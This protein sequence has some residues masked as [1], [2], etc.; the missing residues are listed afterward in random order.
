MAVEE[1]CWKGP[2]GPGG[3]QAE[4]ESAAHHCSNKGEL[5]PVL[6]LQEHY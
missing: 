3:Q 4:H 1:S 2:V 5:D 6:H